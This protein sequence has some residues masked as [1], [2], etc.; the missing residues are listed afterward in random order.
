MGGIFTGKDGDQGNC[1]VRATDHSE[2]FGAGFEQDVMDKKISK[3]QPQPL[4]MFTHLPRKK[5]EQT[6]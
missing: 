4:G 1:D 2:C 5:E 6:T 3:T